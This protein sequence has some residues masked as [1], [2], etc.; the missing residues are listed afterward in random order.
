MMIIDK[1]VP[2]EII[3]KLIKDTSI[4]IIL[5]GLNI[6]VLDKIK[7]ISNNR[8]IVAKVTSVR[9]FD[10]IVEILGCFNYRDFGYFESL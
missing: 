8:V 2:I 7:L 6:K 5:D 1:I 3:D 10:S 4:Y 9:R